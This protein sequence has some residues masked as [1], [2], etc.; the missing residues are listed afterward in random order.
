MGEWALPGHA[1]QV[2]W[3]LRPRRVEMCL[4]AGER[5]LL[6]GRGREVVIV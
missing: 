4:S 3:V 2:G 1:P 6:G 5:D